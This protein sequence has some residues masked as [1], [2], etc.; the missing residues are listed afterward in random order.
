MATVRAWLPLPLTLTQYSVF[1]VQYSVFSRFVG[2]SLNT[3]RS[4]SERQRQRQSA[5]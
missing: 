4:E 1:T 5:K 2:R 3:D